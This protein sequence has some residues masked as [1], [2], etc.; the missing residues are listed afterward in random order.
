MTLV[1]LEIAIILVLLAANGLFAMT[2]IAI[3]SARTGRLKPLAE[4]GNQSAATVLALVENPNR[5]LSTVQIGITL[6]GILAGAF[7]GATLSTRLAGVLAPLPIVGPYAEQAAFGIVIA[8]LTYFSLIIGELLPKRL[9]LLQPEA[10]AMFMAKPMSW[11]SMIASPVVRFLG[12]STDILLRAIGLKG[13]ADRSVSEEDVTVLIREGMVTGVFHR[14]E[15][16]MI[17]GVLSLDNLDAYQLM[18]PRPKILWLEKNEPHEAIWHRIASSYHT[19]FPVYEGNRDNLLGVV[20]IKALYAQLAGGIPVVLADLMTPPMI[21]PKS[22]NATALLESFKRTGVHVAFVV[23]EFGSV[24][25]M[26]TLTDILEAVVGDL[27]APGHQPSSEIKQREDGSWL[28]DAMTEIERVAERIPEFSLP[29][30]AGEEFQTLAGMILDRLERMPQEGDTMQ[31]GKW[32]MEVIDMDGHRI[33]KVLIRAP[34]EGASKV[35]Q[36]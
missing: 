7:G 6:V 26:V 17:E 20:S 33:D 36:Q 34:A 1:V 21:V 25:G 29:D 11:L 10:T 8:L 27:P 23:S 18:T 4:A 30:E 19:Y 24:E 2:E 32:I 15:S 3:V 9:A 16:E 31:H 14:V 22:Q 35:P 28:V 12:W 13:Q 5:F